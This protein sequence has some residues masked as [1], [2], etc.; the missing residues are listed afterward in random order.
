MNSLKFKFITALVSGSLSFVYFY[1]VSQGIGYL[2]GFQVFIELW[3]GL[4]FGLASIA[5]L[6]GSRFKSLNNAVALMLG[7][8]CLLMIG[9]LGWQWYNGVFNSGQVFSFIISLFGLVVTG[10]I[11]NEE[12]AREILATDDVG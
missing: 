11:A 10:G 5:M 3:L 8:P 7:L 1:S 9:A 6:S 12:E 4:G 2:S